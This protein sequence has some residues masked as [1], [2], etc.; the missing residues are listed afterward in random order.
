MLRATL[1]SLALLLPLA[2]MS[3]AGAAETGVKI[4]RAW[5]RATPGAAKTGVIYLTI[6]ANS[7]DRL[8]AAQC[9]VAAET[10][11]HDHL[12]DNGVMKMRKLEDGLALRAGETLELKPG[13]VHQVMLIG[14]R[15]QLK[16]GESFPLTL[17]FEKAGA[18]DVT[19]KVERL[20]A[21]G[22]SDDAG[23]DHNAQDHGA[24]DQKAMNHDAA[25]PSGTPGP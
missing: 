15:R 12:D 24:M 10:E 14:M 1:M 11:L 21:M 23:M 6:E 5:A 3:A 16:V 19:V 8:L 25:K 18:R 20:G 4:E 13:G 9:P 2:A 22:P 7:D 17:F